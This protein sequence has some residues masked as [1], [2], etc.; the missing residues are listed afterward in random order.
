[1]KHILATSDLSA[2][3]DRAIERATMLAAAHRARLTV[4]HVVDEE[5]PAAV[6]DRQREEAEQI[7]SR[8]VEGLA[9][10]KDIYAKVEV[11]AGAHYQTIIDRAEQLD[12]DLIVMG[13]HRRDVL[14]DLFR[15]S[16]GERI[17]R[18]G[19]RPVLVV[20]AR[21][22]HPYVRMIAAVDFSP[23]A[24]KAVDVALAMAPETEI[25]LVHA[26]DIPFRGLLT[27]GK[28]MD[29]LTKKHQLQFQDM[30]DCQMRDFIAAL[31]RTDQ[32]GADLSRQV[33]A[34]EGMPEE[35]ILAVAEEVRCDLVVIG[36][37]GRSGLARALLGS[38]TETV[39]A[40]TSCDVLAVRGW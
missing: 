39:L 21:P 24:R 20:K 26:Y 36:T 2:R 19:T 4:L 31:S 30:V 13:E 12:A 9:P 33:I 6:A 32:T 37:H 40:R 35:V 34:R 25:Y 1:M 17:I 23:P 14:L 16:T 22:S 5:L 27:G 11:V 29:E 18:F 28:S 10:T 8:F 38:V 15:G 3:S 7:L